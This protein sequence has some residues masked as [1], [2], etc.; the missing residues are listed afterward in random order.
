[1]DFSHVDSPSGSP[2]LTSILQESIHATCV[3]R[4]SAEELGTMSKYR[5]PMDCLGIIYLT[6]HSFLA[7]VNHEPRAPW[8]FFVYFSMAM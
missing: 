8:A 5:I 6:L 3:V 7:P 2:V 1:M 4:L